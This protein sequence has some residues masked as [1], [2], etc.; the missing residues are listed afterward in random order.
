MLHSSQNA[1][2]LKLE[3]SELIPA[4]S[5]SHQLFPLPTGLFPEATHG[6]HSVISQCHFLKDTFLVT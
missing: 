6:Q 5:P 4:F 2:V 3:T 1:F